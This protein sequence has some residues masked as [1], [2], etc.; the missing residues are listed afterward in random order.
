MCIRHLD[1]EAVEAVVFDLQRRDPRPFPLA[2]F[3]FD[4]I[5]AAILVDRAKLVELRVAARRNN[6]AVAYHGRGLGGDDALE[7]RC[8]RAVD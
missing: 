6:V 3:Q 5:G 4:Q 7:E 2:R 1:I 8:P